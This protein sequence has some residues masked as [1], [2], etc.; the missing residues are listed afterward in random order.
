VPPL[1]AGGAAMSRVLRGAVRA[2]AGMPLLIATDGSAGSRTVNRVLVPG[3]G[4]YAWVDDAYLTGFGWISTTGAWGVGYCPQPRRLAGQ[5]RAAVAEL[6]AI[7][8]AVRERLPH[9]PVTVL[10]DSEY[11]ARLLA[12]W[13]VGS[14]QMPPGYLGSARH[15]PM[16]HRLAELVAAYPS[17]LDV[18]WVRGHAGHLLNECADSL[19]KLGRRWLAGQVSTEYVRERAEWLASG[20]L[21][22]PAVREVA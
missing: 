21:A 9:E 4:H 20:F 6:R 5:D 11:A 22:D 14:R 13:A 18:R 10:T 12:G 8:H 2:P 15:T 7:W 17:H 16:V 3:T 1:L 19:A